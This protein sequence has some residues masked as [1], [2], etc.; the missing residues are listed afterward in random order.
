MRALRS[1]YRLSA[2][3]CYIVHRAFF[4]TLSATNTGIICLKGVGLNEKL[5]KY[6]VY[7]TAHKAVIEIASRCG[8]SLSRLNAHNG[9]LKRWLCSFHDA[10][11]FFCLRCAKHRNVVFRHN[12]LCC[13]H[14]AQV[15]LF[16][17]FAIVFCCV[18]NLAATV[19]HKSDSFRTNKLGLG[20]PI[21]YDSRNTPCICWR[22]HDYVLSRLYRGMILDFN[23]CIQIDRFIL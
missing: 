9:L 7:R 4:R 3:V 15:F 23:F 11:G 21:R 22:N 2:P 16:G 19:H 20:K 8:K 1:P 18:T 10:P 14:I 5:I 13:S 17:K 12:N 6:R